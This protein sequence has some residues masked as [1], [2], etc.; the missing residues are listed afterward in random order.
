MELEPATSLWWCHRQRADPG[1]ITGHPSRITLAS[2][3][4]G[5]WNHPVDDEV[6]QSSDPSQRL[7]LRPKGDGS[8]S[9]R[10]HTSGEVSRSGYRHRN[11]AG[12][13]RPCRRFPQVGT[14]ERKAEAGLL[15]VPNPEFVD[16]MRHD[17]VHSEPGP[18]RPS[19]SRSRRGLTTVYRRGSCLC[20]LCD[21]SHSDP[22]ATPE[23]GRREL[24]LPRK[25]LGVL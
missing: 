25:E 20:Q 24:V 7:K 1:E 14:A 13:Q 9:R 6:K 11:R 21:S 12:N 8:T 10:R 22:P 16:S 15:A 23:H 19:R 2:T 18:A 17:L 3:S 5:A 4:D